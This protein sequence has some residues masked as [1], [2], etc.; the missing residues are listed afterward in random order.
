[1]VLSGLSLVVVRRCSATACVPPVAL[2]VCL[3]TRDLR[4]CIVRTTRLKSGC[5]STRRPSQVCMCTP[6]RSTA[7][8]GPCSLSAVLSLEPHSDWL[9]GRTAVRG[10]F[11]LLRLSVDPS[12]F[13]SSHLPFPRPSPLLVVS[14]SV[15]VSPFLCFSASLAIVIM[16]GCTVI[17]SFHTA[18]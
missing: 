18:L 8:R 15:S 10:S 6:V 3:V 16:I 1:M 7:R 14:S 5:A 12:V 4:A 11:V 2:S 17:T 13:P 9:C